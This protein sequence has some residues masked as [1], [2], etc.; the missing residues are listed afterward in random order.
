MKKSI[1]LVLAVL[2][3]LVLALP[4]VSAQETTTEPNPNAVATLTFTQTE[5]NN[6]LWVNN[7]PDPHLTDV[8]VDL[9]SAN[10]GQV[11]IT[12]VYTYRTQRTG[13]TSVILRVTTVPHIVN[14]HVLWVVTAA[15]ADGRPLTSTERVEVNLH[16][17]AAWHRWVDNHLP[18]AHFTHVA[19]TDDMITFTFTPHL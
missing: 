11:L 4:M 2:A 6:S 3:L 17:I 19:I 8:L 13:V 12:A 7:P 1:V 15:N 18:D 14:E 5:I 10:G 16:L 9:Q